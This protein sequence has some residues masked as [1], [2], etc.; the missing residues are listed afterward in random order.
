MAG[1]R[2]GPRVDYCETTFT[3]RWSPS[4]VACATRR[5]CSIPPSGATEEHKVSGQA[6]VEH[7]FL[8]VIRH[9]PYS[10]VR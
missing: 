1:L 2:R 3:A 7:P 8:Y 4:A 9:F 6:N 10:N 5:T